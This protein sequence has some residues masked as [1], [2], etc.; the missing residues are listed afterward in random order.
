MLG[1]IAA[2]LISVLA[3]LACTKQE[4]CIEVVKAD[5][6]RLFQDVEKVLDADANKFDPWLSLFSAYSY[7]PTNRLPAYARFR[8]ATNPGNLETSRLHFALFLVGKLWSPSTGSTDAEDLSQGLT[9]LRMLSSNGEARDRSAILWLSI[10]EQG[11]PGQVDLRA[12]ASGLVLGSARVDLQTGLF[13]RAHMAARKSA[14]QP[15]SPRTLP[16]LLMYVDAYAAWYAPLIEKILNSVGCD[17]ALT[18]KQIGVAAPFAEFDLPPLELAWAKYANAAF[19]WRLAKKFETCGTVNAGV[20]ASM[21]RGKDATKNEKI[22]IGELM[23]PKET[24]PNE[25]N[26]ETRA[27]FLEYAAWFSRAGRPLGV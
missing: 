9:L 4:P 11:A 26:A 27:L 14:N 16:E 10:L 15:L 21:A 22:R 1:P 6:T 3:L 24:C 12:A 18:E 8:A 2:G 25:S 20:V 17:L 5:W 23:A 7:A 19:R 13:A